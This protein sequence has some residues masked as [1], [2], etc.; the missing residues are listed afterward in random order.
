[1][2]NYDKNN[3]SSYIQ[4]WDV[5]NVYGSEMPQKVPVNNFEWI[6]DTCLFNEVFT[7]TYNERSDEVY[8]LKVD[9]QYL[10]K[11]PE[12]H[13]YLPFLSEIMKIERVEKLVANSHDKTEY[14]IH[15]KHL[16][17][18]LN[19]GLVFKNNHKKIKL[20]QNG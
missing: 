14:V 11:L 5:N 6:K 7:K 1:M 20:N 17:Q 4:Y 9:V 15:M 16:K 13:N 19:H 8:H 3:E 12:L 10:E 2:Q 18:A